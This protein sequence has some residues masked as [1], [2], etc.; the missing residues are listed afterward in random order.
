M[1]VWPRYR[2]LHQFYVFA[3]PQDRPLQFASPSYIFPALKNIFLLACVGPTA[4]GLEHFLS[5]PFFSSPLLPTRLRFNPFETCLLHC[6][7]ITSLIKPTQNIIMPELSYVIL[8]RLAQ[9][10]TMPAAVTT[11][12][13]YSEI[14]F[15]FSFQPTTPVCKI[16]LSCFSASR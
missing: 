10:L 8:L 11:N 2:G 9:V 12:V 6:S 3:A 7:R 1:R 14:N 13:A 15:H 5:F 4:H 16:L